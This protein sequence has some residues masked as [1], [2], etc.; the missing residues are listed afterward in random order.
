MNR[1]SHWNVLMVLTKNVAIMD[2]D[3]KVP[4]AEEYD[5]YRGADVF[6]PANEGDTAFLQK[7]DTRIL[8]NNPRNGDGPRLGK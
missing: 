1:I 5:D 4:N 6:I 7:Q 3:K 2:K 8:N